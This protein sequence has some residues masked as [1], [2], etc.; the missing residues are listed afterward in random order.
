MYS[1]VLLMGIFI[2]AM[3]DKTDSEQFMLNGKKRRM[4][5]NSLWI[6]VCPSMA[7]LPY[8]STISIIHPPPLILNSLIS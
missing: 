7:I 6:P 1:K 8:L 4:M 3:D 2:M 5:T